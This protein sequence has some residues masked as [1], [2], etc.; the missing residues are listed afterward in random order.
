MAAQ[1]DEHL[2]MIPLEEMEN[3]NLD[4]EDERVV[5]RGDRANYDEIEVKFDKDFWLK[6]MHN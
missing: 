5:D 3:R 1:N 6:V 4:R 2:V